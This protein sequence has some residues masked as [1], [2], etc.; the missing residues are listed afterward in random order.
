MMEWKRKKKDRLPPPV[1]PLMMELKMPLASPSLRIPLELLAVH[2]N[3]SSAAS[4]G[5]AVVPVEVVVVATAVVVVSTTFSSSSSGRIVFGGLVSSN[6]LALSPLTAV[7]TTEK[8]VKKKI[9]GW[10]REKRPAC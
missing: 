8:N 10:T 9:F 6:V 1:R 7:T 2:S 3:G 5:T 4:C